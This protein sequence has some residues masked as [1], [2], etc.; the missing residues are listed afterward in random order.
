MKRFVVV[1]LIL[2]NIFAVWNIANANT[3]KIVSKLDYQKL[4]NYV[5]RAD[6]INYFTKFIS[7]KLPVS[8]KYIKLNILWVDKNSKL[9][10]S[11][12]K[13]VYLN[14][15]NNDE[16][17]FHPN[18]K[19]NKYL[20]YKYA[21]KNLGLELSDKFDLNKFKNE[22]V[23]RKDFLIMDW[24]LKNNIYKI[25]F[26]N[27][28]DYNLLRK[29]KIF[30]NV[31]ETLKTSYYNH[32][33]L[34]NIDLLNWA[35][36]WL[37][38]SVWDKFTVYFPPVDNKNFNASLNW[39][40]E[41]IWAYVDMEQPWVFKIIS[42]ISWSPAQR[43]WLKWWDIV[44]KVD[45]KVIKANNS[46][47]E[48]VSWVKWKEWTKVVL[49]IKRWNKIF[50]VTVTRWKI[51]IKDIEYKKLNYH[52]YY[53][54]LKIFWPTIAKDFKEALTALKKEN[55]I[56]K[57]IID[58]RNNPGGYLWQ[59][60]DVLSYFVKKW[61]PVAVVKYPKSQK[62]YYSKWYNLVDFSKYKIVILQNS[63]SAS[64]SEI[65]IW[66]I[67]DYYP[68]TVLIW[69]KTYWKWSVQTIKEYSDWSSL[70]YTIAKW[71]TW[72]TQTWIDWVWINPTIKVED[73]KSINSIDKILDRAINLR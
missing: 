71:F 60:T 22:Y 32:D 57:V 52:T 38:K 45:W 8:Y 23:Q 48:V 6:V 14:L 64:A 73:K 63:W 33:K 61:E 15:I 46:L 47:A 13:L 58:L 21:Q 55:W 7:L 24:L 70:K 26:L 72:K 43:A 29:E 54:K 59:V 1:F 12:Q 28:K 44:L 16:L 42:P 19:F 11:L 67:K 66:W 2:I 62:V 65:M 69:E 31:Y 49:T 41:W 39:E 3:I 37:V 35:T 36:K 5:D 50:D 9:Y 18:M 34:N 10:D 25:D 27:N 30:E 68:K 56:N 17:Y 20:F 4:N 53:I 51:V 40:Y